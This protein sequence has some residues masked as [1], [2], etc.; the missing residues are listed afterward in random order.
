MLPSSPAL[1]ETWRK[2]SSADDVAGY[3]DTDSIRRK[4][5]ETRFWRELRWPEP[6]S[7]KSGLVYDRM[8]A[9]YVA[10]CRAMTFRS[11]RMRIKLGDRVLFAAKDDEAVQA[12]LPGT[13]AYS[14]LRSACFDNWPDDE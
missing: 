13:V 5:D 6:R 9:L 3:V 12:V 7:L 10:D 14:D 11:L 2:S 1:S 8:A 4:G